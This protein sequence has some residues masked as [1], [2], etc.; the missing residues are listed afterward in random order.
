MWEIKTSEHAPPQS[1]FPF[2][3]FND[4]LIYCKQAWVLLSVG[5]Y[6][7][8]KIAFSAING[9]LHFAKIK[10][11]I[12]NP[13]ISWSFSWIVQSPSPL[14]RVRL[15][16][17]TGQYISPISYSLTTDLNHFFLSFF[18]LLASKHCGSQ[19]FDPSPFLFSIVMITE[20]ELSDSV[21]TQESLPLA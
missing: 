5:S 16:G 19:G 9:D 4:S 11:P 21:F 2:S 7:P 12:L 18:L 8:L 10:W 3:H 14:F 13:H 17:V 6:C 20:P 15:E 1:L